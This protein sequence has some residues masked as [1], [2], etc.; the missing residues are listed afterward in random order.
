MDASLFSRLIKWVGVKSKYYYL[1]NQFDLANNQLPIYRLEIGNIRKQRLYRYT[2]LE[3]PLFERI[4]RFRIE[5]ARQGCHL[6]LMNF[7][8]FHAL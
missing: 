4:G 3:G 7:T 2:I 8:P 1:V 6:V 5:M